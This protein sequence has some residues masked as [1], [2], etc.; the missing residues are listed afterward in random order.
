MSYLSLEY[1]YA[2][3]QAKPVIVF[4]HEQ[5][6]SREIHLQE[7]H[8]QLKDKFLTFRKKLLLDVNHI[9]TLKLHVN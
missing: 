8:P 3:S 1:E 9:F 4:M 7:T 6:E 5:P 2:L